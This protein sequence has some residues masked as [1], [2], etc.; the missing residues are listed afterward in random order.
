VWQSSG[1]AA[2]T[3]VGPAAATTTTTVGPAA[4]TAIWG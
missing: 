4:T 1:R 2:T 3:T